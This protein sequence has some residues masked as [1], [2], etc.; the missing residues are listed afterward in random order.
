MRLRKVHVLAGVAIAVLLFL[1]VQ[2]RLGAIARDVHADR[3]TV[4]D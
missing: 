3:D 2:L 1:L 4:G